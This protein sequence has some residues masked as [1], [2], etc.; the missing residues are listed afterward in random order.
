MPMHKCDGASKKKSDIPEDIECPG[1]GSEIEM[2]TNE[3]KV[4]CPTC[5]KEV[6]R[7][8]LQKIG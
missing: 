4:K 5:S 6:T 2:W 3:T 8:E 1:C 7:D